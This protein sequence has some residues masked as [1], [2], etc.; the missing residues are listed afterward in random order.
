MRKLRF[1]ARGCCLSSLPL[2]PTEPIAVTI[3]V[4]YFLLPPAS[5]WPV[6]LWILRA[7]ARFPKVFPTIKTLLDATAV[8]LNYI[9]IIR[10]L[11]NKINKEIPIVVSRLASQVCRRTV[12]G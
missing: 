2:T 9:I 1:L 8:T 10:Y 11:N 3:I 4:A 12:T 7:V 6:N 5:S